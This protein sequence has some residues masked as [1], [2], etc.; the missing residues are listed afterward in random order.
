MVSARTTRASIRTRWRREPSVVVGKAADPND[1]AGAIHV[2]L[3][4]A[5]HLTPHTP[6]AIRR[7]RAEPG[8][9]ASTPTDT[10]E[11]EIL[12]LRRSRSYQTQMGEA[13]SG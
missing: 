4:D 13:T 8:E 2:L 7:T 1:L 10:P 3:N 9:G 5:I 11:L 6:P 12:C